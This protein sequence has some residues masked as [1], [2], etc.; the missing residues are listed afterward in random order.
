[1]NK[2]TRKIGRPSKRKVPVGDKRTP[3]DEILPPHVAPLVGRQKRELNI[4]QRQADPLNDHSEFS[5]LFARV[6]SGFKD[7]DHSV[8]MAVLAAMVAAKRKD[9]QGYHKQFIEAQEK[10]IKEKNPPTTIAECFA[11]PALFYEPLLD[12]LDED[13]RSDRARVGEAMAYAVEFFTVQEAESFFSSIVKMKREHEEKSRTICALEAYN[14]YIND[15][16]REPSKR[17]LKKFMLKDSK[18]HCPKLDDYKAW[19][20]MW[21]D[22]G[23]F[24]LA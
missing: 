6:I 17:T 3:L 21:Q 23:L 14:D 4:I 11:P 16:W 19:E 8:E 15:G 7:Q 1:M 5:Q 18:Y 22:S 24:G 2:K 10:F 12:R 20:R 13:Q 9:P